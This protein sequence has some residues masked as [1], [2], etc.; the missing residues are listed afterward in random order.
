[1][2]AAIIDR[3]QTASLEEQA[4]LFDAIRKRLAGNMSDQ[5]WECFMKMIKDRFPNEK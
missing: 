4:W 2:R 5:E 1:M 3:G